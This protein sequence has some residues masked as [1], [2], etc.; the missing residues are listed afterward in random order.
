[1]GLFEAQII[2][3][4]ILAVI[5]AVLAYFCHKYRCFRSRLGTYQITNKLHMNLNVSF[6][7]PS[8]RVIIVSVPSPPASAAIRNPLSGPPPFVTTHQVGSDGNDGSYS[9]PPAYSEK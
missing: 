3:L 5:S 4:A 6:A 8:S 9:P 1:M 7:A 2:A